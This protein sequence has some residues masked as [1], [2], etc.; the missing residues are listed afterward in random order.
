MNL[1][2][3]ITL[4]LSVGTVTFLFIWCIWKVLTVPT[5]TRKIH[6]FERE[7]PDTMPP[8]RFQPP[9]EDQAEPSDSSPR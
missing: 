1:A 4:A 8:F 6:G 5:D 2:G 3:W 9:K 7:T